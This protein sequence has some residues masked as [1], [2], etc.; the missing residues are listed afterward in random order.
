MATTKKTVQPKHRP[1]IKPNENQ[2]LNKQEQT[3]KSPVRTKSESKS[4]DF[5]FEKQ[6]YII[7]IIGVAVIILGYI[8]M[9]GG[10]SEDPKVFNTDIFDF[11]RLTLAP[12]VI[13]LGFIIEIY[14]IMKRP[15][16][17]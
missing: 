14:A 9:V 3:V 6:N 10:G 12:I 15:K 2:S 1:A 5:V 11:R 13:I 4:I 7:M 17:D 16:T 8:L